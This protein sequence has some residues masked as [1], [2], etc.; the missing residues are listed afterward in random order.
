MDSW[1]ELELGHSSH[2]PMGLASIS[3][4]TGPSRAIALWTTFMRELPLTFLRCVHTSL[5]DAIA[6]QVVTYGTH[7]FLHPKLQTERPTFHIMDK[8]RQRSDT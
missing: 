6:D 7:S 2:L 1:F 3:E 4:T 8:G 5:Q